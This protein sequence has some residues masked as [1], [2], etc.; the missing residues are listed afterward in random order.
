MPEPKV[1][2]QQYGAGNIPVN[3]VNIGF[4]TTPLCENIHRRRAFE[5]PLDE[6]LHGSAA[7]EVPLERFGTVGEVSGIVAFLAGSRSS[8]ITG[9]VIDVA[10]GMGKYV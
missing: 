8:Y 1:L 3:R 2:A 4:V 7:G 5:Q 10:G 6:F 9:A